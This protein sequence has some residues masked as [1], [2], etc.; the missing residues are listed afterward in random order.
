[1]TTT[2]I[3][4]HIKAARIAAGM[5]QDDLAIKSQ[6]SKRM[7]AYIESGKASATLKTLHALCAALNLKIT[8]TNL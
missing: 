4:S 5:S 7:I 2:E 3:T 1:M 6:I 8:I